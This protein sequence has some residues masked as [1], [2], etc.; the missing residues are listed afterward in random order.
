MVKASRQRKDS[1]ALKFW[2]Y[3]LNCLHKL[4]HEGMSDEEDATVTHIA[5]GVETR[6]QVRHVLAPDFRHPVLRPYLELVDQ[7]RGLEAMIFKQTGRAR[8]RR[9]RVDKIS[10]R[11]PPK[12]LPASFFR[13]GFL[14][15]LM[16]HEKDDL[17][18]SKR[19]FV[20]YS[21][22]GYDP[23]QPQSQPVSSG[24]AGPSSSAM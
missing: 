19:D 18:I 13:D 4:K 5:N 22:P 12:R 9:I 14:D 23:H 16:E 10:H 15:S 24:Q 2:T 7:T 3:G 1:N 17:R 8:M 6:E 21:F 20:L 11:P